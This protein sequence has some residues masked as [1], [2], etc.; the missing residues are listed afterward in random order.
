[1]IQS[2][3]KAS[4]KSSWTVWLQRPVDW[5]KQNVKDSKSKA[6]YRS[7]TQFDTTEIRI[8]HSKDSR[9]HKNTKFQGGRWQ[10]FICKL[11]LKPKI[12]AKCDWFPSM[13]NFENTNLYLTP[14]QVTISTGYAVSLHQGGKSSLVVRKFLRAFGSWSSIQLSS[15]FRVWSRL[16]HRPKNKACT[17]FTPSPFSTIG[18]KK[19]GVFSGLQLMRF[20]FSKQ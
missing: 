11:V 18:L 4:H 13:K 1:M 15:S 20:L 6:N 5:W 16:H 10:A 2:L 19:K 3:R 9:R 12:I 8:I 17:S 14:F 7:S